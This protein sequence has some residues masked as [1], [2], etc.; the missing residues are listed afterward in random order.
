VQV[1]KVRASMR[2]GLQVVT[3]RMGFRQ[4]KRRR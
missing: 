4:M 3:G 2:Q 1:E